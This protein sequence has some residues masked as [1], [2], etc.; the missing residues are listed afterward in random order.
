MHDIS[1]TKNPGSNLAQ[2]CYSLGDSNACTSDVT[3]Y[4]PKL[5]GFLMAIQWVLSFM[6]VPVFK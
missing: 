5:Y 2:E 3:E 4:P 1:D 6:G